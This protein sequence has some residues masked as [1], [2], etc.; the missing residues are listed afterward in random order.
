MSDRQGTLAPPAPEEERGGGCG[1]LGWVRR[2]GLKNPFHPQG[3]PSVNGRVGDQAK[4]QILLFDDL[5]RR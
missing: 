1:D 3:M 5:I 4:P 2:S